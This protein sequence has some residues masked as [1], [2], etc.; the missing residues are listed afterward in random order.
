LR[1]NEF[2]LLDSSNRCE[3]NLVDLCLTGI[4][5]QIDLV[6]ELSI[7]SLLLLVR[8]ERVHLWLLLNRLLLLDPE[9]LQDVYLDSLLHG[10]DES[11]VL[12][13]GHEVV[14]LDLN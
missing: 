3:V 10:A 7:T 6:L 11:L 2:G 8:L 13:L 9:F 5:N 1:A 12:V 4:L 14:L